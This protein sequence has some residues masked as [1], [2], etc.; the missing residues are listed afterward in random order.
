MH[1]PDCGI[2]TSP[3]H[4]FCR[5]CGL[6]L[7]PFARLLAEHLPAGTEGGAEAETLAR[8]MARQRTVERWLGVALAVFLGAVAV[9]IFYG[10]I[11]KIIIGKGQLLAGLIF[12]GV[13]LFGIASVGLVAARESLKEKLEKGRPKELQGA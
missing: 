6:S 5:A 11:V 1:C 8:L 13:I 2:M 10:I 9:G 7:E 3:E 12:L 4:R